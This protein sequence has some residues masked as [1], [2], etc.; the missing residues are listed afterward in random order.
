MIVERIVFRAKF[1]QGD[2]VAAAFKEFNE[3][4][5]SRSG[6]TSRLLTDLTG[7]MFTIVA[8]TEYRDLA[9]VAEIEAEQRKLYAD[10]EWQRWF[11]TWS[12]AV[13]VGS[14]ELYQTVE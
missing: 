7:T 4:M 10:P 3:K 8:E 13:E 6:V 12:G 9:H 14:R 2:T 1:G 5:A 11:S